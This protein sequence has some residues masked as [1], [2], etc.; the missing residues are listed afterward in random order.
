MLEI[1]ITV[2]VAVANIVLGLLVY[3][4]NPKGAT[5]RLLATLALVFAVWTGL[6]FFSLHAA[7]AKLTLGLIRA[8]MAV[9]VFKAPLLFLLVH[10]YPGNKITLRKM[11]LTPLVALPVLA[12]VLALT[13]WVFPHLDPTVPNQIK[14]V[15]G[16]GMLV[17]AV[18]FFGVLVAAIG[19][20]VRRFRN[21]S[22]LLKSQMGVMLFGFV[23]SF[24]FFLFTNFIMVNV[25]GNPSGVALGPVFTIILV[26]SIFYSIV[27]HRLFDV[28]T[29][30]V[31]SVAF[32]MLVAV[33]GVLYAGVT[34]VGRLYLFPETDLWGRAVGSTMAA[35]LIAF[36]FQELRRRIEKI[37]DSIFYKNRYS[38]EKVL[39]R[40]SHIMA[41]TLLLE[42]LAQLT[43]R[44]IL[45]QVK[46]TTAGMVVFSKSGEAWSTGTDAKAA[47]KLVRKGMM[48]I[49][50]ET[51][52]GEDKETMRQ[53][54][55]TAV[56]PL[57][58][59][60]EVIG[61][62]VLGA[63]ASGDIYSSQDIN[64]IEI[65]AP[66]LAVAVKN[67]LSYREIQMFNVTLQEEVRKATEELR[68]ANEKLR[69][70]DRLKDEF[71]SIASHE[72][73]SPAAVVKNYVWEVLNGKA[74][75]TSRTRDDLNRAYRANERLE[76]LVA[77]LL[78]VSRI[79]SGR[80]ELRPEKFDLGR[81]VQE[82]VR[83]AQQKASEKEMEVKTEIEGGVMVM[84]D[85][86]KMRQVVGNFVDNAIKF[87]PNK[88]RVGVRVRVAE[89][90][91]QVRVEDS[92]VGIKKEDMGKL[93]TKFGRIDTSGTAVGR[94]PGTGLGL[95]VCKKLVE[96]AGGK[97]GVE[98]GP[99]GG[100][101]FWF[102][103]PPA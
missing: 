90:V 74:R 60:D 12:S 42:D 87:T 84:V 79:E 23:L 98:A 19:L 40:L 58:V 68:V 94:T 72:L 102:T 27:R 65:L 25:F 45:D 16:P 76:Q 24:A 14:P 96:L 21:S 53:L 47:E 31:R 51:E 50:D 54:K 61:G 5:N 63:K 55:L 49:F 4:N 70:L 29:L 8:V 77:D 99:G 64:L 7:N 100:S 35:I 10:T 93:F 86:D 44:E 103:L 85:P 30:V 15:P 2:L 1:A 89:R 11:Y 69:Q 56:V 52:E 43:L 9:V 26:G 73:R 38:S 83:D 13:P 101:M 18:T 36:T 62:M 37:T 95:Y 39:G 75:L 32:T 6:N 78:D 91:A 71:I 17:W 20:L 81:V 67:A 57:V 97:I 3:L 34:T 92:G 80:I 28:R 46:M 48:V 88:G 41:S 66:E 59:K 22:G 33:V 82:V